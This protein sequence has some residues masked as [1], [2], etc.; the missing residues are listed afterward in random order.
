M[1]HCWKLSIRFQVKVG[2]DISVIK[3]LV[4]VEMSNLVSFVVPWTE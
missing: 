2:V 1:G 3:F 4:S